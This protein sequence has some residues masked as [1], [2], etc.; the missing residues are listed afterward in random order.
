MLELPDPAH[1][2]VADAKRRRLSQRSTVTICV[3][4][5]MAQPEADCV[6][7]AT[8]FNSW[9]QN[10]ALVR[11]ATPSPRC[12][13]VL[14]TVCVGLGY[15][16]AIL[17]LP[18]GSN[19]LVDTESISHQQW[20]LNPLRRPENADSLSWT[21]EPW[22]RNPLWRLTRPRFCIISALDSHSTWQLHRSRRA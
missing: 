8:V 19:G 16:K 12:S 14:S 1:D 15:T 10:P 3:D 4:E 13:P 9:K 17:S 6:S 7:Q 18:T 21:T 5:P 20:K 11:K 2:V 22:K